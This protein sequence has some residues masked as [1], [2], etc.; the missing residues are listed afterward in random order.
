[1]YI[2]R[3][4]L[5][6]FRTFRDA[7][8]VFLHADQKFKTLN[9]PVP[10]WPNIN[11]CLGNNG[12]GK[13][14]L[15]RA[16]A[17]AALGPAVRSSGIFAD[18]LIR[19]EPVNGPAATTKRKA[20]G[21]ASEAVLEAVFTPHAQDRA[22][23][24]KKIEARVKVVRRGD[25]EEFEWSHADE[26]RWHPIFSE[27][28]DAFFFV[29][30]GATRRVERVER[31]DAASR[32]K[33]SFIRAQRVQ[34]LFEDSH[35]LIPL[36]SWLPLLQSKNKGRYSQVVKLINR[37]LGE[38]NYTFTGELEGREYLFERAGLQIPF[39]ALSDGYRAYLS[40]VGDLLYH[41]CATCPSGKKLVENHGIVMVDEI[42]LHLHPHWQM[43]VL[44]TLSEALPNLQFIVTSHSPLLVG[45]LEWMNII[46]IKPGLIKPGL[47][48]RGDAQSSETLR[49][50]RAV[51]GL[52]ADQV[53]LTDFFGLESTRA[54][55]KSQQLKDLSLKASEGDATAARQLLAQM[56]QGT[57]AA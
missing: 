36:N 44:P 29:G 19:R 27:S 50:E 17:L 57:E 30:Y 39:P 13:T 40:W 22:G 16:I 33:S 48:K 8:I 53:L 2:D 11:L 49:V 3:L 20:K 26:K 37:L 47:I 51:H 54:G 35:S 7:E 9:M 4:K 34:G 56:S 42:D 10:R 32:S 43:T 28:S 18:R 21:V 15:L 41:V 46:L 14:T 52:D 55:S 1:M 31:Y 24:Q 45:S 5:Q 23:A 38:G 6:N 25:L 12:F